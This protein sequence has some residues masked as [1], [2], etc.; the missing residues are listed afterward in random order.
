MPDWTYQPVLRR[1]LFLSEP[2]RARDFTLRSLEW[3]GSTSAG[4]GIIHAMGYMTQP[5]EVRTQTLG[6][7]FPGPVGLGAGLDVDGR[8]ANAFARF[9]FGFIEAGPITT[10]PTS[11]PDQVRRWDQQEAVGYSLPRGN[12]GVDALVARLAHYHVHQMP[13]GVWLGQRATSPDEINAERGTM[14]DKLRGKVAYFTVDFPDESD[15]SSHLSTLVDRAGSTPLLLRVYAD[16]DEAALQPKIEMALRC[17]VRGIVLDEAIRDG[18]ADSI[19]ISPAVGDQCLRLVRWLRA[20]WRDLPIIAGGGI[21]DPA[22]GLALLQAGATLVTVHSGLVFTGPGLPKRINE[23][24]A[25]YAPRQP[26]SLPP[27]PRVLGLTPWKWL[28][29]MQL[30]LLFAGLLIWLVAITLVVLPYD[31]A[32]VGLSR[33][34]LAAV[35]PNLLPFMTHDRISYAS[36]VISS[37]ILLLGAAYFALRLRVRW[38]RSAILISGA[39]SFSTFFLFLGYGYLDPLHAIL[40]FGFLPIFILGLRGRMRT[41][42][43]VNPPSLHNDQAWRMANWGQLFFA[44][45]GLGLFGGGL[46]IVT[47]GLIGVFVPSDLTFINITTNALYAASPRMLSLI[48]HDRIG[49][50]GALVATGILTTFMALWGFRKG[51]RWLWWTLVIGGP[52]GIIGGIGIHFVVGYTDFLHLA[53]V[54]LTLLL[55]VL[56]AVCAYPYLCVQDSGIPFRR[57]FGGLGMRVRKL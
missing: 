43:V 20:N 51:E 40:T 56:G 48:A 35:N 52:P 14:I 49:F 7:N 30:G 44:V 53:P 42:A 55:Y 37:T 23:A 13:I 29:F 24:V 46:A 41:Y 47:V 8:A 15:F 19:V 9:G 34:Q 4:R 57:F 17:G 5:E 18:R 38:S 12:Q 10:Q 26:V 39:V 45:T 16:E 27:A 22:A 21:H 31:E 36:V 25:Y 3:L 1:W 33:A 2:R 6:I 28:A 50:G 11:I 54:Y 32:F